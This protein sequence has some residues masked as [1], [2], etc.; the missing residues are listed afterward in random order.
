M[1]QTARHGRPLSC[2]RLSRGGNLFP[3]G[4]SL[5]RRACSSV[6]AGARVHGDEATGAVVCGSLESEAAPGP[7]RTEPLRGGRPS[8][9]L[10]PAAGLEAAGLSRSAYGVGH[11]A[12]RSTIARLRRARSTYRQDALRAVKGSSPG[13]LGAP[14]GS[15]AGRRVA[16]AH[17]RASGRSTGAPVAGAGPYGVPGC[18]RGSLGTRAAPAYGEGLLWPHG[19]ARARI[20][21]SRPPTARRLRGCPSDKQ[22]GAPRRGAIVARSDGRP[23]ARRPRPPA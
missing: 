7:E 18:R 21:S 23:D 6:D 19:P 8:C 2:S 17:G 1:P 14:G 11:P 3:A 4:G 12:E 22:S 20:R 13:L 15:S 16:R 9:R 10:A 5:H